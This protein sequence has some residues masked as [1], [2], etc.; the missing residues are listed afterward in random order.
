MFPTPD[1]LAVFVLEPCAY[2]SSYTASCNVVSEFRS[3]RVDK[4]L[5]DFDLSRSAMRIP[6]LNLVHSA[7]DLGSLVPNFF[8]NSCHV[9]RRLVTI[10]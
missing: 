7:I 6:C 10:L 5:A 8:K 2:V 4:R 9:S 1:G 3:L